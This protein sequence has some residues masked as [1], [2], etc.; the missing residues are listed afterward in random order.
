MDDRVLKAIVA[1]YIQQ[2]ETVVANEAATARMRARRYYEGDLYDIESAE[3]RSQAVSTDVQDVVESIIPDLMEIFSGSDD[4]IVVEPTGPEDEHIAEQAAD[5]IRYVLYRDNPGFTILHDW[6]K[7]ALLASNGYA[8]VWWR[9]KG[10]KRRERL[11]GLTIRQVVELRADPNIE[12][13][14]FSGDAPPEDDPGKADPLTGQV[15]EV[16]ILRSR[17]PGVAIEAIPAEEII[18]GQDQTGLHTADFRFV[19]RKY[20]RTRSQ[21][22]AEGYDRE[23]IERLPIADY[24]SREMRIGSRPRRQWRTGDRATEPVTVYEC[25]LKVDYDGDGI[26]EMRQV[27]CAG[28]NYELLPDPDTKEVAREIDDHPI[29]DI[30]AVRRPHE[31]FGRAIADLVIDIQRMKSVLM[32]QLLDNLYHINNARTAANQRVNIQDLLT[33]RPGGIVRVTGDSPVNGSLEPIPTV[34]VAQH[35]LPAIEYLDGV[36]ET[37]TGI[38]R[39]NQGLD[40]DSLNKTATGI[41][42]LLNRTQAKTL[43][44]ARMMAELGVQ[45]LCRRILDLLIRHQ[46]RARTVRLRGQWV[47]VDPRPWNAGMDVSVN[48]SLGTGTSDQRAAALREVLIMQSKMIEAQGGFTPDGILQADH[49]LTTA[50]RLV[51]AIGFKNADPFFPDPTKQDLTP[52]QPP[53]PDPKMVEAQQE[54]QLA[55]QEMQL[56]DKREREKIALEHQRELMKLQLERETALSMQGSID[57]VSMQLVLRSIQDLAAKIDGRVPAMPVGD[58]A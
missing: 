27:V 51:N 35:V 15:Y 56:R 2:A 11:E 5:Y 12:I 9:E 19:A 22:I 33:L 23:Q 48:V 52:R 18:L 29:Y 32:R 10:E 28:R 7:E 26:A 46:D 25:Y 42:R 37:R 20:Q 30:C 38:T 53:A 24:G 49:V 36:R 31:Q 58:S 13:V 1:R 17:P 40:P 50:R 34:P 6:I 57:N 14:G 39:L 16:E 4:V 54:H 45:P 43:W 47:Q 55:V 41:T 21:L 8:M 44:I 3:G